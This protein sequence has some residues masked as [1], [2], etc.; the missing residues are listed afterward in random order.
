MYESLPQSD[1]DE[2]TLKSVPE[3]DLYKFKKK[4]KA[5]NHFCDTMVGLFIVSVIILVAFSAADLAGTNTYL[6]KV[7]SPSP[8]GSSLVPSPTTRSPSSRDRGW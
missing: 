8:N 1:L 5:I 3:Q 6:C 4:H 7:L 2:A